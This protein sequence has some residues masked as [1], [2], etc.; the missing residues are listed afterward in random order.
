MRTQHVTINQPTTPTSRDDITDQTL[1]TRPVLPRHHH[2]P[3]HSLIRQQHRLDLTR[4]DPE[5]PHLHLI[6]NPTHP[7]Q[8]TTRRPPHQITRP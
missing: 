8:L 1:D 5:P 6:I 7:H 4:L 2:R 3:G